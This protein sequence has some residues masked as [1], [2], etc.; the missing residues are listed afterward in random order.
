MRFTDIILSRTQSIRKRQFQ[1]LF[2][3]LSDFHGISL[4]DIGAAGDIE[5]RWK[6]ISE[7]LKYTGFEP[8]GRSEK[9]VTNRALECQEYVIHPFAI[10]D[11]DGSI[12]I[13]MLKKPVVSSFFPPNQSFLNRFPDSQ[14]FDPSYVETVNCVK[15]DKIEI[16][17]PDFIKID[18]QG[19]ELHAIIGA[20]NTLNNCIGIELEVEFEEIYLGQPLFGEISKRLREVGFEFYD[21]LNLCRWERDSH[22]GLGQLVFGDALFLKTP[23][24]FLKTQPKNQKLSNYLGIL[25]LYNRFDLIEV[26]SVHLDDSQKIA[27]QEFFKAAK[28]LRN[29]FDRINSITGSLS[30]LLKTLSPTFRFHLIH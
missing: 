19:G 26:V 29:E 7:Y 25:A 21:F 9:E 11:I 5:P 27:F 20:Q 3:T 12:P 13:H 6:M 1:K 10:W 15:L 22:R 2:A 30:V 28:K 16:E 4:I 18:I 14:R 17:D 23:E 24:F 8:D